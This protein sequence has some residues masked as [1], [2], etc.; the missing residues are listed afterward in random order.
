MSGD[1][2]FYAVFDDGGLCFVGGWPRNES[3]KKLEDYFGDYPLG[4]AQLV[5][6][7][8]SA[9]Q[10][11]AIERVNDS[12]WIHPDSYG[13]AMAFPKMTVK[14]LKKTFGSSR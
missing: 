13:L 6:H 7:L 2:L 1:N 11:A 4:I 12:S 10:L 5:I 8:V 9:E 3:A 14:Q